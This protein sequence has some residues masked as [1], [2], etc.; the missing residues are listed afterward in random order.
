MRNFIPAKNNVQIL[1]RIKSTSLET[2]I[3]LLIRN[4]VI[5]QI[6]GYVNNC[7][8][9]LSHDIS[10]D[11]RVKLVRANI[12]ER[13]HPWRTGSPFSREHVGDGSQRG[14]EFTIAE[15]SME[16]RELLAF[17]ALLV[18]RIVAD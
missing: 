4:S 16:F 12:M 6:L 18:H 8:T 14:Y 1:K 9:N 13:T 3:T 10:H 17:R 11:R 2:N 7:L 15:K 5:M